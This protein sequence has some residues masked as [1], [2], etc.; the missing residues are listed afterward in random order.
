M[1]RF[2]AAA[3]IAIALGAPPAHAQQVSD[4]AAAMQDSAAKQVQELPLALPPMPRDA[5]LVVIDTGPNASMKFYIDAAS[6]VFGADGVLR[7]SVVAEGDRGVRNLA[8]EGIQ[9]ATRSRKVY[10]YG[11]A[12]G[13]WRQVAEP[14]WAR[15]EA[16]D[17]YRYVLYRD[18][19]CPARSSVRSAAEAVDALKRGM[20]P[21]VVDFGSEQPVPR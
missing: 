20:N 18:Y 13:T 6:V 14:A 8:F 11:R 3:A 5:D 7:Y 12:D 9:C 17:P 2:G 10:A 16:T 19:F 15:I 1:R 4:P 21:R